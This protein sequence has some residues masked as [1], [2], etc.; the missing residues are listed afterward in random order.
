[1][2]NRILISFLIISIFLILFGCQSTPEEEVVVNKLDGQLKEA[3]QATSETTNI[4]QWTESFSENQWQETYTLPN[5]IC[6]INSKITLP[7]TREFPVLK[8]KKRFF[9]E[10]F[11]DQ[12]VRYFTID[13]TGVRITSPTKEE[14]TQQLIQAKRGQYTW[15]DNGGRW[16]PY[17]GQEQDIA[18]LEEQIKNADKEVFNQISGT[19]I[20]L[21]INNTYAIADGSR[22]YVNAT[23]QYV[24]IFTKKYGVIQPESWVVIGDAY[25]GEPVGTTINDIKINEADARNTVNKFLSDL[26]INN[27]GIAKTEKARII[28]DYTFEIVSKGWFITL[29][30]NDGNSV[31]VDLSSEQLAG[32]LDFGTEDYAERWLPETITIFIDE[33]GIRSFMWRNPVEIVEVMNPNVKLLTFEDVKG[34]IRNNIQFGLSNSIE[35]GLIKNDLKV[36]VNA[37]ILT[38]VLVPIKDDLDHQMLFPAWLVYYELEDIEGF[39]FVFAVNAVDGSSID[40]AMRIMHE[41]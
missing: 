11:V 29:T 9:S 1:M 34:N 33:T 25:P 32:L 26:E 39:T 28:E 4:N 10:K 24:Y 12:I 14:L 13:A 3:I 27:F 5:L 18:N 40:L 19:T 15:D 16:E 22:L 37:I 41:S 31:P 23:S 21:P 38:N 30:R 6:E 8:V 17:E 7:E 2:K 35:A 36:S 20:T